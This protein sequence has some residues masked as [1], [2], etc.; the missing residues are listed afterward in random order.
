MTYIWRVL[1]ALYP[2]SCAHMGKVIVTHE[3]K[4]MIAWNT[5]RCE[6]QTIWQ[7]AGMD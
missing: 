2:C 3:C 4:M 5:D 7:A 6:I 1:L